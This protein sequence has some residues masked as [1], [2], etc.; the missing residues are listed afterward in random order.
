MNK[1]VQ[2][3]IVDTQI[4]KENK[5]VALLE[6]KGVKEFL[7]RNGVRIVNTI[8][9]GV[10]IEIKFT[11][12]EIK[13][14]KY[15]AKDNSGKTIER[16]GLLTKAIIT[17]TPEASKMFCGVEYL[18]SLSKNAF[19]GLFNYLNASGSSHNL[20]GRTFKVLNKNKHTYMWT[21][22]YA[23]ERTNKGTEQQI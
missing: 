14:G 3:E 22:V 15:P 7:K 13:P 19:V 16:E 10:E 5:S 18:L 6:R 23:E 12:D 20:G 2:P 21:E 17:Y 4:G 8:P 1:V 9:E 11:S